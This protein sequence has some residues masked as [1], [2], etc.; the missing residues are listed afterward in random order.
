MCFKF[1]WEGPLNWIVD[2]S[3]SVNDTLGWWF[4]SDSKSNNNFVFWLNDDV[5]WSQI[6]IAFNWNDPISIV[7]PSKLTYF[8]IKWWL[9]QYNLTI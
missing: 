8:Q 1:R 6:L 4:P 7:F 3:D 2:E 5:D 9:N